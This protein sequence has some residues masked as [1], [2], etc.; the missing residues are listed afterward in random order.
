MGTLEE[1]SLKS[2]HRTSLLRSHVQL[3]PEKNVQTQLKSVITQT[4][5]KSKPFKAK[6]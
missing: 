6:L 5:H 2:A 3:L 4:N 1:F